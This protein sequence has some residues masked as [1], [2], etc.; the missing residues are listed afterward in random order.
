MNG[1]I[2]AR[3]NLGCTEG[4]AGNMD[5]AMKHFILAA[6]VGHERSLNNVKIGF[7]SGVVTK[8][9]YAST[10]RYQQIQDEMKSDERDKAAEVYGP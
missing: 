9:V 6:R 5:R 2:T 3:N 4:K 10:L 7:R 1:S 8:D